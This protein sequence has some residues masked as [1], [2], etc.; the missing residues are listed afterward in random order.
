[1]DIVDEF[2]YIKGKIKKIH[3]GCC[4]ELCTSADKYKMVLPQDE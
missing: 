1:M 3:N 4:N 2:G